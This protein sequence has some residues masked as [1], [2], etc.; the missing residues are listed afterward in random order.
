MAGEETEIRRNSRFKAEHVGATA[1]VLALCTGGGGVAS[2]L[3]V[4][5]KIE[6]VQLSLAKIEGTLS[7]GAKDVARLEASFEDVR[8]SERAT[9]QL[10]G[11]LRAQVQA[12]QDLV[13]RM[14][15][16]APK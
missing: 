6:A 1:I 4:G 8:K 9:A 2:S 7:S 5:A 12:L 15:R 11:E 3:N 14:E 10:A 16:G 13:R